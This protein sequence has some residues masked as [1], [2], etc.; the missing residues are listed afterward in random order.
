MWILAAILIQAQAQDKKKKPPK[1]DQNP[2]RFAEMDYGPFKAASIEAGKGQFTNKGLAI[3]LTDKR[4]GKEEVFHYEGGVSEFVEW[5]NK[6]DEAVHKVLY[7]DKVV[8]DVRVEVAFQY[9]TAEEERVRCYANTPTTPAAARTSP[10][11]EPL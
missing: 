3:K 8:D 2:G 5:L 4:T 7:V 6:A 11:S 1:S 9:T 10:A